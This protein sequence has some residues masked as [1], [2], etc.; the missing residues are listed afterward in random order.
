MIKNWPD[1]AF[2]VR[3]VFFSVRS[4]CKWYLWVSGVG[5]GR[6]RQRLKWGRR[7]HASALATLL[8]ISLRPADPVVGRGRGAAARLHLA[9]GRGLLQL[10]ERFLDDRGSTRQL[11]WTVG[12][13]RPVGKSGLWLG[14]HTVPGNGQAQTTVH[15]LDLTQLCRLKFLQRGITYLELVSKHIK[16]TQ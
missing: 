12:G 11:W 4:Q 9:L 13:G 2:E 7:C 8:F 3:F 6:V 16:S 5:R 10:L 1:P 15:G 14:A